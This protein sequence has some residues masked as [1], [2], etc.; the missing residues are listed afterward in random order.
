MFYQVQQG[1]LRPSTQPDPGLK[2]INQAGATLLPP[3]IGELHWAFRQW[4]EL[5]L[6][7]A[8]V[9]AERV[10]V[11]L[12]GALAF[13]FA[14][15]AAPRPLT[16]VGLARELAAWLVLLDKW[17]ETYVVVARAR[18]VWRVEDLGGALTFVTPA[19][20]PPALVSQPP[21]N[22]ERVAHALAIVA[23]DGPMDESAH[24]ER[25]WKPDGS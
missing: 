2:P 20:L 7:P 23:L 11:S 19:F 25:H 18:K 8:P 10:W 21:D 24:A 3:A 6:S 12:A 13:H 5:G 1:V 14:P 15:G 17:M 16:H 9:T 22:W 4:G